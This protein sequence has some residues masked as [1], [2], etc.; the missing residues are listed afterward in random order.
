LAAERTRLALL[1]QAGDIE[2]GTEYHATHVIGQ[3]LPDHLALRPGSLVSWDTVARAAAVR[4]S[5]AA[6]YFRRHDLTW[7]II[8]TGTRPADL[9]RLV[10]NLADDLTA[11]E[12]T[13]PGQDWT[14]SLWTLLPTEADLPRCGST[15]SSPTTASTTSRRPGPPPDPASYWLGNGACPEAEPKGAGHSN[16]WHSSRFAGSRRLRNGN[17]PQGVS[18]PWKEGSRP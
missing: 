10:T 5:W 14:G 6:G 9:A 4:T 3:P 16:P 13:A 8:A 17:Q 2:R 1:G 11:R 18:S 7:E 12:I 15:P